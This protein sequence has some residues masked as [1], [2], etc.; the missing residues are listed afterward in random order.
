MRV[1]EQM[2][3]RYLAVFSATDGAPGSPGRLSEGGEGSAVDPNIIASLRSTGQEGRK[4]VANGAISLYLKHSPRLLQTILDA[5][6]TQDTAAIVAVAHKWKS[7]SSIV[8][9][10]KLARLLEETENRASNALLVLSG[11]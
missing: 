6:R 8:G 7:S 5:I 11:L 3:T 2:H 10:T 9:A 1:F 4:D